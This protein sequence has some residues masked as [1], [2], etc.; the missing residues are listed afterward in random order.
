MHRMP[1]PNENNT[2]WLFY[3]LF[4]PML[5][6]E[7][8]ISFFHNAAHIPI[9]SVS[10]FLNRK[11]DET[12]WPSDPCSE[13]F[14]FHRSIDSFFSFFC[15]YYFSKYSID[16]VS[17]EKHIAQRNRKQCAQSSHCSPLEVEIKMIF[18]S[19]RSRAQKTEQCRSSILTEI[20]SFHHTSQS[21]M[22]SNH[23]HRNNLPID[24]SKC[25]KN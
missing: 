18:S 12:F 3:I 15:P 2:E 24:R 11:M 16:R 20:Y 9:R 19:S 13:F 1:A 5:S 25:V 14:D 23:R 7:I 10:I 22:H 4:Y 17:I 6:S 21:V 8:F